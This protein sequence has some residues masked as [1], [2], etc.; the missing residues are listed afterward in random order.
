M[1]RSA[2][3]RRLSDR[4]DNA[5]C[6]GR[7]GRGSRSSTWL[8][9]WSVC[10]SD[11]HF[12][13]A[14]QPCFRLQSQSIQM[15]PKPSGRTLRAASPPLKAALPKVHKFPHPV[16]EPRP[17]RPDFQFPTAPRPARQ[18]IEYP[19]KSPQSRPIPD[20]QYQVSV[21]TDHDG[22]ARPARRAVTGGA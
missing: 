8:P 19:T 12:S 5:I 14:G 21:N 1:E 16:G 3:I 11:S 22:R 20:F 15:T 4:S 2:T 7:D 10:A 18:P 17:I 13:R 6:Y 9:R